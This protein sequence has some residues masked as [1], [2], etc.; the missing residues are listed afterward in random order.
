MRGPARLVSWIRETRDPGGQEAVV[1]VEATI[2]VLWMAFPV[3][4]ACV[5]GGRIGRALAKLRQLEP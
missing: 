5:A 2:V 1:S 4:L 3:G